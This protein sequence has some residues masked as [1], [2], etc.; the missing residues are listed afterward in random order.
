MDK[1][2]PVVQMR[3][4][5]K[6]F[7]GVVA[8]RH[9]DLTIFPGEVHA[10]LGENGAGKTTLMNILYGLYP[11][12]AGE[13]LV[14]GQKVT[15]HDPNDAIR[16]GI[17]MVHQH[18][19]VIPNFTVAENIVLGK[20]PVRS[21]SFL[22]M[23]K[24]V[25]DVIDLSE[26][27]GLRVDPNARV[28]TI[29]VGMQQ[30]VEILKALYR[31]ADVLILD[32]P[33]AVLTPQ[34]VGELKQITDELAR[35]GKAVIFIT[36]KL[37]EVKEMSSRITVIRRGQVVGTVDT[38]DVSPVELA[39]MMVGRDV[40]LKVP[41]GPAKPGKV[42]L[43]LKGVKA[44]DD[45]GLPALRG[46][47]L[48]IRQGEIL[49]LAG[50]DGNG[51]SQLVEVISGLRQPTEGQVKLNGRDITRFSVKEKT[52]SGIGHIPEDRQRRG[53]VMDFSVAENSVLGSQ[54]SKAFASGISLCYE[55]VRQYARKLVRDYDVRTS[56]ID[57]PVSTLSGGNQQKIVVGR[58][59][60][61]H[62]HLLIAA[63]P[64]RGLDVG[65]IEFVHRRLI[66]H[67]D[68]GNAV[69]LVSL[70][71][72]EILALSDRIAVIYEGRIVAEV[73]PHETTEEELGLLMA[74]GS[75]DAGKEG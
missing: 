37:K 9:I 8:N 25:K 45:R 47:D 13:I 65:A 5:V 4:I 16:L 54:R 49:G 20:E 51:Q 22:D 3:G 55:K 48:T 28:E 2:Q 19:M 39:N 31:G 41:K 62:P 10:L 40:D 15:I 61:R 26:R 46:I 24:A 71:L 23:A 21:R 72:D 75:V 42:I 12:D 33:T 53:L 68:E 67:R 74:G 30:R 36:H 18:F 64:T 17:G 11:P 43:E 73:D 44:V 1:R 57:V 50:V 6:T 66:K 56:G 27:F 70:E 7:P 60:D 29:S 58:E 69:L 59:I 32:E 35:Q 34:E 38:K 63:Q 52:A 14:R